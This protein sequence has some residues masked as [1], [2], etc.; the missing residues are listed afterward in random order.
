MPYVPD[1]GR[2]LTAGYRVEDDGIV[3]DVE[4]FD[5][6]PVVLPTGRAVGCDP[7]VALK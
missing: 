6:G 1:L 2:L 4:P 5:L 7:L 3:Y